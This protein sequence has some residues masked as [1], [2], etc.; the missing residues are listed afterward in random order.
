MST[1]NDPILDKNSSSPENFPPQ[2]VPQGAPPQMF[3]GMTENTF[4]MLMHL[5][6]FAGG[7]VP[8][9]GLALPIIMWAT[10]KDQS[11][12]IDQ[13]GK[14]ILNFIISMAIYAIASVIL[15]FIV[16]G[17]FTLIALAVMAIVFPIMAAV[18]AN[19]GHYWPYPLCIRF[20]K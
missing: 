20:F 10:N 7:V 6:Q 11:P 9:A 13:H 15:V 3:W 16:V 12:T 4:C 17:I 1:E 5:A 14:N 8:G 18:K 19:D 2:A